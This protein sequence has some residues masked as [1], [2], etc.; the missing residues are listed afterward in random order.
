MFEVR[1]LDSVNS[2]VWGWGVP[3]KTRTQ[4]HWKVR[5]GGADGTRALVRGMFFIFTTTNGLTL[6]P[7]WFGSHMGI[8]SICRTSSKLR[9][10]LIGDW[11]PAFLWDLRRFHVPFRFAEANALQTQLCPDTSGGWTLGCLLPMIPNV[12]KVLADAFVVKIVHNK[13]LFLYFKKKVILT[14]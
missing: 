8:P 4:R 3:N 10:L 9:P 2:T 14:T 12:W 11:G 6:F 1:D 13:H 7:H 5:W